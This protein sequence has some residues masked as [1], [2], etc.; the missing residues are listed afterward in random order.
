M[1]I[2]AVQIADAV[3]TELNA[4]EFT[5]EFTAARSFLPYFTTAELANIHVSV[6]PGGIEMT[7]VTRASTLDVLSVDIGILKTVDP[8]DED[9]IE[10]LISFVHE[11]IDYMRGR[12]LTDQPNVTWFKT[13]VDPLYNEEQL[14]QNKCFMSILTLSYKTLS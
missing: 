3:V 7:P 4:G 8:K 14:S 10:D 9:E 2:T 1:S 13:A 6:V 5:R 12:R 11:I